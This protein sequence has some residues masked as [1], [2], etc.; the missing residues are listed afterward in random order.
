[1]NIQLFDSHCDTAFELYRKGEKLRNNQC[2]I[3]LE[4]AGKY[5]AYGQLFA[6]CSLSGIQNLPW[7]AEELLQKPLAYLQNEVAENSDL[8]SFAANGAKAS[9]LHKEGKMAALLSIEGAEVIDCDI[10]RLQWLREQGFVMTTLTW[11]AD[12]ILA[13]YHGGDTGLSAYGRDFVKEAQTLK[14]LIDVSHLSEASFWDLMDCTSA[15]IVASHSNCRRLWDHS[16]NL[17]D[18]Q[19]RAIADTGGAVGLNLYPEFLSDHADFDCLRRHLEHMLGLMGEKHVMLGGDLDGCE[20]LAEGFSGV[21]SYGSFY[22]YLQSK[23][24]STE[25]LNGIFYQNLLRLL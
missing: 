16:R 22:A 3:D 8:I 17:T 13:G 2:H 9:Q 10:R 18:D 7:T 25:L 6:F 1:M 12:N 19:L 5:D 23:G 24:Y 4:R 21:E 20:V 11:N 15:P 14:I